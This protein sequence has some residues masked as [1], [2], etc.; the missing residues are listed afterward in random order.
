MECLIYN[1]IYRKSI[2]DLVIVLFQ[3]NF[4]LNKKK[5]SCMDNELSRYY[6]KIWTI[7][8]MV[9]KTIHEEPVTDLGSS[10]PSYTTVT[11]WTKRFRQ[12]RKDVIDHPRSASLVSQFTDENTQL[13]RQVISNDPHSTYDEMRERILSLSHDI[14]EQIIHDCF[15][16]KKVTSRWV[17]HELTHKQRVKLCRE[18][19]AKFQNGF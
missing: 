18:N 19:L 4:H 13:L 10:A 16:M 15:K 8:E 1:D 7:L 11:R 12:G 3:I 17:P 5:I 14:I 9:P 2:L 6:I